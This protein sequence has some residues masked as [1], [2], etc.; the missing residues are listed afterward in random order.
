M[1]IVSEQDLLSL[2]LML[3]I[4]ELELMNF[5]APVFLLSN[6]SDDLSLCPMPLFAAGS[7]H[8]ISSRV[9]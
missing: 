9:M 6:Q 1:I 7:Q 4:S 8:P 5:P 2:L 3:G